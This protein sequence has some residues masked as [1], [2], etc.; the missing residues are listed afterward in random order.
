MIVTVKPR[1]PL[2]LHLAIAGVAFVVG[3][4]WP[5]PETTATTKTTTTQEQAAPGVALLNT[6]G[7][8]DTWI[9]PVAEV[10]AEGSN[11][12]ALFGFRLVS[13]R[14]GSAWDNAGLK[15]GDVVVS[16]DGHALNEGGVTDLSR[17]LDA[18]TR[19][20]A[21]VVRYLRGDV[22]ATPFTATLNLL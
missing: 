20:P 13:V 16:V 2:R 3:V 5:T 1:A 14:P 4:L 9:E 18:F 11:T 7:P 10:S 12:G 22:D 8:A 19:R 15:D 6:G 17:V 21:V